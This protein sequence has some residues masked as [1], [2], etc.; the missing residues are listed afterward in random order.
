[1]PQAAARSTIRRHPERSVPEEF[2]AI[3]AAGHVA[4]IGFSPN[5]QPHVIPLTYHFDPREPDRV[6]VHGARESR[7]LQELA[8]GAAACV[9]VTAVDGLVYSRTAMNH[10]M[11]YRSA[12]CFG[13]GSEVTD[14][15][16]KRRVFVAMTRRYFAGRTEG[17][18]YEAASAAQLDATI[19]VAIAIEDG[20]AK[21]RRG[22]PLGPT[23]RDPSA[24][25][26]CGVVNVPS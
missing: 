4:H 13:R 7:T 22:G 16:I 1:M 24:I 19:M 8:R 26:T 3:M 6:Y 5:G 9:C 17:V 14:P 18:D 11:N 10:S 12:I 20:S 25:G 2:D 23:D 21:A 15:A